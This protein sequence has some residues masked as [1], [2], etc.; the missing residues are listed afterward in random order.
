VPGSTDLDRAR[1]PFAL[2]IAHA[3]EDSSVGSDRLKLAGAESL[4]K[5]GWRADA[6]AELVEEI[7]QQLG[8]SRD[9]FGIDALDNDLPDA[10]NNSRRRL[11]SLMTDD[12][13]L[14][15]VAANRI[16]RMAAT[17]QIGGLYAA[18]TPVERIESDPLA[19]FAA[20]G[21]AGAARREPWVDFLTQ[22]LGTDGDVATPLSPL[23]IAPHE[24]QEAHHELVTS[25]VLAP[26]RIAADI[27][28][29][30]GAAIQVRPYGSGAVRTFDAV[31]R[32]DM[33]GPVPLSAINLWS[34]EPRSGRAPEEVP[35]VVN[36]SA[37]GEPR[38]EICGR[39]TCAAASP[40]SALPC[41]YTGI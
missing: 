2:H 30:S 12:R 39:T 20:P 25:Y 3:A 33:V 16:E 4:V 34:G 24:V 5:V 22:T 15:G 28:S 38:C 37:A 40:E 32:I 10:T 29:R 18:N 19:A 35:V 17:L 7:R 13:I 31:V 23:G 36:P 6:F 9:Q 1:L 11:R 26:E 8:L 14:E 27:E 41:D 21:E